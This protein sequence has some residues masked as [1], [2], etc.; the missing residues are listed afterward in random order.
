MILRILKVDETASTS[1]I[2]QATYKGKY[3]PHIR[4]L[5]T[6]RFNPVD[7]RD[8]GGQPHV[9]VWR[10]GATYKKTGDTL[11]YEPDIR[12]EPVNLKEMTPLESQFWG[13]RG[14]PIRMHGF[15]SR[16]IRQGD[17]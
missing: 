10:A 12:I 8:L 15:E 11:G 9:K 17:A 13:D 4:V 1:I 2:A 6:I 14:A 5:A 16:V 3:R 7:V